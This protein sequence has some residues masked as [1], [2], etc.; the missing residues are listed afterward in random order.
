[1]GQNALTA[2]G[3]QFAQF[4]GIFGTT[5]AIAGAVVT[6]G[7][8][9]SQF[10]FMGENAE[11]EAARIEKN[12]AGMKSA[13]DEVKTVIQEINDL[14][15]TAAERSAAAANRQS[16]EL[17]T[18][19]Q[20]LLDM[21]IQRNESNAMELVQAQRELAEQEARIARRDAEIRART[22][23]RANEFQRQDES[24]LFPLRQRII[25]LEADI[26]RQNS[27]IGELNEALSRAR[28][29][30]VVG[31]EEFGPPAPERER[32]NREAEREALRMQRE[33]EREAQRAR[34]LQAREEERAR[35]EALRAEER[36][37]QERER[38]NR[39]ITDDIVRYSADSFAT[40]W[41]NTGRGFAGLMESM[42]QMVRRTFARIAAEAIIRPI[43]TPI[44]SS[45]VSPIMS[46]LGVG[47]AQA[48]GAGGVGGLGLGQIFQG[49]G[50]LSNLS[51]GGGLMGSLGLSG[52]GSGINNFLATPLFGQAALA[53][54]TNAALAALPGGMLGPAAPSSLGF[55]GVTVGGAF[56]A[57]A[58]GFG[59]GMLTSSIVGN[60]RGTVGP[61]GMI[62]A[63]LGTGLGFLVGGPLGAVV[64]GALGGGGGA[65]FGPTRGG[66]ASR[67]GGDVYLGTDANGQLIITGARGKR[68]D[69]G[70]A[71]SEVQAQI[72]AINQ[73]I[74][75]R[76]LSFAGAGQAAV[77]FGAASGSPRELSLT[78]LVGQLRGGNANQMTAFGTLAGRGGNLE[79]ALQ[80]ADFITQIYEPLSKAGEQT[81]SFTAAMEAL[82]KT[83]DDAI[84]KARDLGLAT[85]ALDAKR[86][87]SLAKLRADTQRGFDA[88]VRS[89]RGE[90]FVDQLMGVRDNYEANKNAFL[91]AGR[92][93]DVLYAAQVS[94]I[95]NSLDAKQL[96]T[97]IDALNGFDDVAVLFARARKEQLEAAEAQIKAAEAQIKAAE[98][99]QA[100]AE[101][102]RSALAAGGAIRNYLD[103]LS[104]TSAG[105]L[106]PS[107]QFTNA[108]SIFGRDLAL[109]RGGDLDALGRITGSAENLLSA[110]R[111]MFASGSEFQALLQMVQ[112]SLANLPAT[113]SYEQ[114]T[115]DTLTRIAN[116]QQTAVELL[117]LLSADANRD[118]RITWPEFEAWTKANEAQTSQLASALGVSNTSL[119]SIFTQLDSNGD[120]TLTQLEIQSVL[121]AAANNR[122]DGVIS[123]GTG[124]VEQLAQQNGTLTSLAALGQL[125]FS[126]T[127][128]MVA[129]LQAVNEN[130]ATGN[131]YAAATAYNTMLAANRGGGGGIPISGFAKGGVFD[132]PIM[133]PMRDGMG[134]MGE[135]G[136]EAI[137]PLA[138]ASDG[139]LGVRVNGGGSDGM[140][141]LIESL[142]AEVAE[143]RAEMR[144]MADA[145]ERTADATEDTAAT[146]STMARREVIVGR[147]VA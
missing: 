36:A 146:N 48:S 9:A 20:R 45:V 125:T 65:M 93:P 108:Q 41:S 83:Y 111:G 13:A 56:G 66:M 37:L 54:S 77:G 142:T 24:T 69:E 97:A 67:S 109:S 4:A 58:A 103:N 11:K 64:G 76:G 141:K 61:G 124:T 59:A 85:E 101:R 139:S 137:M 127:N 133:F 3:V 21:T 123:T 80:A 117:G 113:R 5:G 118:Q 107:D 131:R 16:A 49:A 89:A 128:L 105:G 122:L 129:N 19:A 33:A 26:T 120:G 144:R 30:G 72:D 39:Q 40:L 55:G 126:G 71:R 57:G 106:S 94:A 134:M 29:A 136:P 98:A 100:T 14:F 38:L 116:G 12:F 2:F 115:L 68:F 75:V 18:N 87:E 138:R 47:G 1:M 79:Q 78:S 99:A 6:V 84:T 147:R 140:A 119:A 32:N 92:N 73:Q 114:Q 74:G 82:A 104:A 44:V 95:V 112:S 121:A 34:E 96:A 22:G 143:L 70:A 86:A 90:S 51:G 31:V 62:G 50:L 132:G 46:A 17:A 135:A 130:L 7:L 60:M 53:N 145:G 23:S 43:V 15:L 91:A 25:G 88:A 52:V 63:G 28:N 81:D 110:G 102:L 35:Q 10:L 42:L 8:L 27:R